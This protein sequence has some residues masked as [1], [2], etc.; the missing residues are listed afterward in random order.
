[1]GVIFLVM[2]KNC[3]WVIS[4]S[5]GWNPASKEGG[6]YE[7][8]YEVTNRGGDIVRSFDRR[9]FLLGVEEMDQCIL[10]ENLK[11]I[12]IVASDIGKDERNV[13]KNFIKF[14]AQAVTDNTSSTERL[15]LE[16]LLDISRHLDDIVKILSGNSS[17]SVSELA[18]CLRQM[19]NSA[20]KR[21]VL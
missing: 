4:L 9:T 20:G 10:L 5:E 17:K 6:F 7:N 2:K 13:F 8:E 19:K 16:E 3:S 14:V 21:R 15:S 11:E 12:G 18:R 1:M